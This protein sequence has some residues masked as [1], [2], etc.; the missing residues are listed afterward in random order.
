M[1]CHP[2]TSLSWMDELIYAHG[3]KLIGFET[4]LTFESPIKGIRSYKHKLIV[5]TKRTISLLS[6]KEKVEL[7][8]TKIF[9]ADIVDVYLFTEIRILTSDG[10]YIR[11]KNL[12]LN[13]INQSKIFD[14]T[15]FSG[16]I[17]E[18]KI[19]IGTF[20]DIHVF[21]VQQNE[22][23][24]EESI[25]R[26]HRG[27]IF[28]V[29]IAENNLLFSCA[30]DRK[31]CLNGVNIIQDSRNY[32]YKLY[33]SGQK[34]YAFNR[35]GHL[36]VFDDKNIVF[37]KNFGN[38][39]L[40]SVF[41]KSNRIY[42]GT[43]SSCIYEIFNNEIK[44]MHGPRANILEFSQLYS[45]KGPTKLFNC[46]AYFCNSQI[47]YENLKLTVLECPI[48]CFARKN[49]IFLLRHDCVEMC[50]FTPCGYN[51]SVLRF[52]NN[53]IQLTNVSVYDNQIF[54]YNAH[55]CI[56]ICVVCFQA[57][58]IIECKKILTIKSGIVC[59]KNGCIV[60]GSLLYK[61][62]NHA[63]TD[64]A[65]HKGDIF[66]ID[67]GGKILTISVDN[68]SMISMTNSKIKGIL[69]KPTCACDHSTANDGFFQQKST[70]LNFSDVSIKNVVLNWKDS[71]DLRFNVLYKHT[72]MDNS[73]YVT[74]NEVFSLKKTKDIATTPTML[75][76]HHEDSLVSYEIHVGP[77]T[78]I[79]YCNFTAEVSVRNYSLLGNE[80]GCLFLIISTKMVD[81][82]RL[83]GPI[84]DIFE[85]E[86]AP[87]SMCKFFVY[88]K[89]GYVYL[90][91]IYNERLFI[92]KEAAFSHKITA[93]FKNQ[94]SL[95]DGRILKLDEN[96]IC[97]TTTI[98]SSYI[99]AMLDG[100]ISFDGCVQ[101]I[102][103]E[104]VKRISN[105]S[106]FKIKRFESSYVA[107]GDDH[108]VIIFNKSLDV[109]NTAMPHSAQ[110]FDVCVLGAFVITLSSD[111]RICILDGKLN[112]VQY[113][114]HNV[115]V[116]R[117]IMAVGNRKLVILGECI[118]EIGI[119]LVKMSLNNAK[120]SY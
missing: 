115:R 22:V 66:A 69:K 63:I 53:Q 18:N 74:N 106:I 75:L 88:T 117:I 13:E 7:I 110:I 2:I 44:Q 56:T 8:W 78:S 87:R 80:H 96:L 59:T 100:V 48:D 83:L 118:E 4:A 77:D 116:P 67:D 38:K 52:K 47:I 33:Y 43:N 16:Q 30:E 41:E 82:V 92:I 40:A 19:L 68:I 45:I 34:L 79:V 91:R 112:I 12:S 114:T 72:D 119:D 103:S 15:I 84:I 113:L 50:H 5:Y 10:V 95:S 23:S 71:T 93:A 28:D 35:E 1:E 94:A 109:L 62:S 42:I 14:K 101:C 120:T 70:T 26:Y 29:M 86:S 105:L 27:R 108:S 37:K 55:F 49:D 17:T 104:T 9:S 21:N 31:V 60:Y 73:L 25:L 36:S 11:I 24:K 20:H 81:F 102:G 64:I 111:M 97:H 76:K 57:I 6:K 89:P 98:T 3:T 65:I 32:F 54:L 99:T 85:V 39:N 90:V 61:I 51:K 58:Q 107:V 46:G